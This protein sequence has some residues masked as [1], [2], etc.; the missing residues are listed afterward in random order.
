MPALPR[1]SRRRLRAG[2][3]L[4][5]VLVLA[6][7]GGTDGPDGA[8]GAD[9]SGGTDGN[10][11][12]PRA[13]L[14]AQS[15]SEGDV[16]T[17]LYGLLLEQAGFRVDVAEPAPREEYLPDLRDGT[18]QLAP[19]YV[20]ALVETLSGAG[21]AG[22]A[23]GAGPGAAVPAPAPDLALADLEALARDDGLAVLQPAR[24]EDVRS[25]AVTTAYAEKHR[26]RTLG[27]LARS[28]QR[29]ALAADTECATRADCAP[30]LRA[31]YGIRLRRIVP[32]GID[33]GDTLEQLRA[34]AVQLAQVA[35]TD[36]RLDGRDSGVVVLA[37]DRDLQPSQQVVPVANA[38]WVADHPVVRT[39]MADL[40][41]VLTTR[42]L[43]GLNAEVDA[44]EVD[45]REAAQ[46]WLEEQGL[47]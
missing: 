30:G 24:A 2:A 37:D 35:S 9:G 16:L 18:A 1:P 29:V 36:G 47:L 45:A 14:V 31:A 41:E 8:A 44:G 17:S 10:T 43:R 27:D 40:A 39:V 21:T 38:A 3:V 22:T 28:G 11:A 5:A 13:T 26:L 33:G 12:R 7:C 20:S 19:D 25:F 46:T 6:G 32:V 4:M 34:G 42:E 23:P 15:T